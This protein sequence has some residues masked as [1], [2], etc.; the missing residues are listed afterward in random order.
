MPA[1]TPER[2]CRVPKDT[3]PTE[4]VRLA[5]RSAEVPECRKVCSAEGHVVLDTKCLDEM[6]KDT[7]HLEDTQDTKDTQDGEPEG[8][9][10]A[11]GRHG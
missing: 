11:R 1:A 8:R 5:V 9:C 7:E 2:S 6:P 4:A 10:N 3:R